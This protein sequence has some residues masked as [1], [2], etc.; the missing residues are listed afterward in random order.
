MTIATL[1]IAL[2]LT[3]KD[4]PLAQAKQV[5]ERQDMDRAT[6]LV[7]GVIDDARKDGDKTLQAEAL[8]L[9]STIDFRTWRDAQAWEHACQAE[10]LAREVKNDTL[11]ADA[12]I[13]K[14][15]ICIYQNIDGEG[16]YRD[17]EGLAHLQE[18][19][20]YSASSTARQVEIQYNIAQAYIGMNR[21]NNPI[22]RQIYALAGKA[23]ER[24]DSIAK[25][26]GLTPAQTQ[27]FAY[28]IR[29]YQQGGNYE[30][31]IEACLQ[32]LEL[33]A[34]DNYLMQS[35]IYDHLVALYAMGGDMD[36]A[37]DAHQR[38][39]NAQQF[40]M[41]QKSDQLLQEME[42][43][44]H[45]REMK[46]RISTLKGGILLLAVLLLLLVA[47]IVYII[48]LNRR[49]VRQSREI[50]LA[51][52]VKDSLMH[53]IARE[54]TDKASFEK[55]QDFADK[56][57]RMDDEQIREWCRDAFAGKEE[58][59][60]EV[61]EYLVSLQRKRRQKAMETGLTDREMEVIRCCREGLSNSEIA[62]RMFL[63]VNTVKNHKQR[64]FAKLDVRSVSELLA[65]SE[66]IGI[67]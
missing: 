45:T 15:K 65:V 23:I 30:G 6:E 39:M 63:S 20:R 58:V 22:D 25:K 47:A 19:W 4:D 35:Q 28:K 61:G 51:A 27:A 36:K 13:N 29:Y 59:A 54:F 24:G 44:Y 2:V 48:L 42:T 10:D 41:Q 53:L 49:V 3:L 55:M 21:L 1:I 14:G 26:A 38:C 52:E 43:S 66:K 18:A 37:V 11:L 57:S 5:L 12:L 40:Y 34:D 33:T 62:D 16:I 60:A 67:I 31:G 9:L 56:I 32:T 7:I 50:A 46:S 8:C 17:E 64:I